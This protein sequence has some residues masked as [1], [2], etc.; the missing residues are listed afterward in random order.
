[1]TTIPVK[2]EFGNAVT[3]AHLHAL[4]R[5]GDTLL[6]CFPQIISGGR[7]GLIVTG[8]C[9]FQVGERFD[10]REDLDPFLISICT[11]LDPALQQSNDAARAAAANA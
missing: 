9:H 6:C 7:L 11:E 1:M 5:V 4:P 3:L 10:G 2:I 8:V